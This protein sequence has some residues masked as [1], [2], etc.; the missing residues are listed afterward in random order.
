[1]RRQAAAGGDRGR[2]GRVRGEAT[3]RKYGRAPRRG[4]STCTAVGDGGQ[5]KRGGGGGGG[6]YDGR[7]RRL[8]TPAP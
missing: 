5:G 7:G 6:M 1:M 8:A 3:R 4:R 2:G